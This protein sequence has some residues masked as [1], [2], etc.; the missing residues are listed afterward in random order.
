MNALE[1]HAFPPL[2]RWSVV[3]R[4]VYFAVLLINV[5]YIHLKE[6]RQCPASHHTIVVIPTPST[7]LAPYQYVLQYVVR[8]G[9]PLDKHRW[10]AI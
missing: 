6:H 3:R 10:L 2:E 8:C 9:L 5:S 7:S 1:M 4:Y